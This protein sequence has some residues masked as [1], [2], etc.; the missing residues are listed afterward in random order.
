MQGDLTR[1]ACD[2]VL[3][4][5]DSNMNVTR[6]W[7]SILPTDLPSGDGDWL[8]VTDNGGG[9]GVVNLADHDGRRVRAFVAVDGEAEPEDV[10]RRMW[11]AISQVSDGLDCNEGRVRPLIGVPLPGTGD[12]GLSGRR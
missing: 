5:C 7:T 11:L 9:T 6:A 3:I 12:G 8:R 2:A 1:L 10:V 4:P